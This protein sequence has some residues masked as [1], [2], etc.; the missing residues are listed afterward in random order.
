M[1]IGKLKK[2]FFRKLGKFKYVILILAVGLILMLLPEKTET[3]AASEK[4]QEQTL[5]PSPSV[6]ERLSSLL[7]QLQGAGKTQAMLTIYRG[8]QTLYQTDEDNSTTDSGTDVSKQT[9]TVTDGS[10]NQYGLIQQ[11]NPPVYLGAIILSQG[12]D[13]PQVRL[14]IV[15]AVS[16][17]TGLGADKICVL[18]MK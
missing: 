5:V 18:K 11:V 14:A 15:N 17:V 9:V 13:D 6:E 8:E 2:D 7:S 10:R 1:E 16:S 3:A 4:P 12:A